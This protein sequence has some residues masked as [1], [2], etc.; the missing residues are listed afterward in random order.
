MKRFGGGELAL[1]AVALLVGT[2]KGTFAQGGFEQ[3]S[4]KAFESAIPSDFY[5][6]GNRIPVDRRNAAVLKTPAGGRLVFALLTTAGWGAPVKQKYVG[7]LIT[8]GKV[9]VGSV[10]LNAGSYGFG[11][12]PCSGPCAPPYGIGL[13]TPAATSSGEAKFFLYNQAGEKVGDC[14][15]KKD[16]A[17]KQPKPLHIV[18]SK[19]AGARLYLGRYFLEL[20]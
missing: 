3:V 7:M 14:V 6:E 4:G 20:K 10:R 16:S 11:L 2:A 8:G 13:E 19:E 15:A 5:L 12:H 9:S 18:L 1:V 17:V